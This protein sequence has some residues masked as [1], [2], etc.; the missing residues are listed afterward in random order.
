MS[1]NSQGKMEVL[2]NHAA[3][4]GR[5]GN[6]ALENVPMGPPSGPVNY[7]AKTYLPNASD[8]ATRQ[9]TLE[10]QASS[11]RSR[12]PM[13]LSNSNLENIER[14]RHS[15]NRYRERMGLSPRRNRTPSR[16][17]RKKTHK[18]SPR[19]RYG[20]GKRYNPAPRFSL[21]RRSQSPRRSARHSP[22]RRQSPSPRRSARHS[23][24]PSP[25]RSARHSPRRRQSPSPRR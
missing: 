8:W 4:E 16:E 1:V 2:K 10:E 13:T 17:R 7:K 25:R 11:E 18:R 12:S 9:R 15:Y 6:V 5:W 3:L 20:V 24:R 21:R 23:P 19:R 14:N 22:R